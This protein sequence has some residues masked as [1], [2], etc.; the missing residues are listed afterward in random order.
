MNIGWILPGILLEPDL[1]LL[2]GGL[3]EHWPDLA[4]YCHPLGPDLRLWWGGG[5]SDTR[6][7]RGEHPLFY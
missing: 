4:G 6:Q 5:Q 3:H 2:Q 7:R 1:I